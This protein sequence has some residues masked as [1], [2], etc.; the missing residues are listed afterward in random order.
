MTC[1]TSGRRPRTQRILVAAGPSPIGDTFSGVL[2]GR[3]DT[4]ES[5]K[6]KPGCALA[7]LGILGISGTLVFGAAYLAFSIARAVWS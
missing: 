2:A 4:V 5:P 1:R 7:A 3:R 6:V